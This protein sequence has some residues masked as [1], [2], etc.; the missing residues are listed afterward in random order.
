M[1]NYL[2]QA[3]VKAHFEQNPLSTTAINI[4]KSDAV[5]NVLS[6]SEDFDV[7][8]SEVYDYLMNTNI[9]ADDFYGS[10]ESFYESFESTFGVELTPIEQLEGNTPDYLVHLISEDFESALRTLKVIIAERE[11]G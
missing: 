4:L 2:D 9:N 3:K 8:F 10:F 1:Y 6:F 7:C 11:I 5:T